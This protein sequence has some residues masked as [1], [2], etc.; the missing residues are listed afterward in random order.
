MMLEILSFIFVLGLLI[1]AHELGHFMLAKASGIR[2]ETFSLGF[3]PKMIGFR[4]GET[5]YCIAGY[6]SGAMSKWREKSRK[7]PR[8]AVSR[9][10]SC[11][12]R[13]GSECW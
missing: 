8:Y 2:V 5:E 10:S 7:N 9:G 11:R 6:R 3:P 13:S 4:K 1:F 12:N